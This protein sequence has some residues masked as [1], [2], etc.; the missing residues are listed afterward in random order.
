M[1]GSTMKPNNMDTNGVGRMTICR[2]AHEWNEWWNFSS[3]FFFLS[4]L[5]PF[6]LYTLVVVGISVIWY[7]KSL[8]FEFNSLFI[9]SHLNDNMWG[10]NKYSWFSIPQ[11]NRETK[12]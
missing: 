11:T 9:Y 7:H 2:Y 6:Y 10:R 8:C 4:L 12:R 1:P 5:L 3:L